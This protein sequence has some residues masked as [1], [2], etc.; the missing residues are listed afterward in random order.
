M[1][2]PSKLEIKP[3]GVSH[4]I[5]GIEEIFGSGY[6]TEG[7]DREGGGIGAIG[8]I[9]INILLLAVL[10]TLIWGPTALF[11]IALILTPILLVIMV[12][13]TTDFRLPGKKSGD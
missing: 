13:L 9:G 5:G 2:S 4:R 1:L 10:T 7:E 8:W 11:V 3:N 6:M 12:G